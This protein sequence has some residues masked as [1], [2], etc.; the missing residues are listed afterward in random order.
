MP[1]NNGQPQIPKVPANWTPNPGVQQP[2]YGPPAGIGIAQLDPAALVLPDQ[3]WDWQVSLR[4]GIS[5]WNDKLHQAN[6]WAPSE[7]T[8]LNARLN[9]ALAR[10]NANRMAHDPPMPL[11]HMNPIHVPPLTNQQLIYQTIRYYNGQKEYHFDADYL[12]SANG[13]DVDFV[14]AVRQWVGG[15]DA[16]V[17]SAPP[18]P[19]GHWGHVP[20]N[21]HHRQPWFAFPN[22]QD[23]VDQVRDC[24]NS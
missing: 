24:A 22:N 13:F 4:D 5:V 23:Y 14:P 16:A 3:Y 6:A 15:T 1:E 19:D 21:L 11:I 8:R 20:A 10:A 18:S 9:A 17:Y 7:Q 12:L 2:L